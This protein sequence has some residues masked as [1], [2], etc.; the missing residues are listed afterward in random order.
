MRSLVG[1]VWLYSACYIAYVYDYRRTFMTYI[2]TFVTYIRTFVTYI[3][4]FTTRY[5]YE[6]FRLPY[7]FMTYGRTFMTY[8]R[9]FVTYRRTFT[10][11]YNYETFR[12]PYVRLRPAIIMKHFACHTAVPV[13]VY[14]HVRIYDVASFPAWYIYNLF[15]H[16]QKSEDTGYLIVVFRYM[17]A[18]V[19]QRIR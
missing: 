9:T 6:T 11:R 10:T 14:S 17:P 18:Y 5:N 12:L 13:Y 8:R 1:D 15:A 3:R 16:P 19:Q 4:T 2:R 7:T